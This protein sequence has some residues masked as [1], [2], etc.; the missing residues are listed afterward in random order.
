M[1][2]IAVTLSDIVRTFGVA[3]SKL[4]V[5]GGATTEISFGEVVALVAPSG[6]R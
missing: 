6:A 1:S 3:E 5:L 2:S 4:N